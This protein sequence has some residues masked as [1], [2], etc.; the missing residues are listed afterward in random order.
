MF[1]ICDRA[2]FAP[3]AI[4][5]KAIAASLALTMALSAVPARADDCCEKP[6]RAIKQDAGDPF[7]AAAMGVLP[8]AS[9]FYVSDAPIKGIVF[10]LA[11]IMLIGTIIQI[12]NND[13]IPRKD[14][15]TYYYLLGAVNIADAL[16]SV[17]QVRSDA[18]KRVSLNVVPSQ[19]PKIILGVRF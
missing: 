17:L 9:G 14:V 12:R 1:P 6:K 8:L 2:P 5:L 10:T 15:A 3:K 16:L 11:D 13:S 18:A 7:A 19:E 4:A